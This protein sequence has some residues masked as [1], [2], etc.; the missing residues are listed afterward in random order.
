MVEG[1]DAGAD[2]YMV[3]PIDFRELHARIRA[4]TKREGKG[5][6]QL[7]ARLKIADLELNPGNWL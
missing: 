6:T 7:P 2:D 3:K 4:L 1:L 5:Q